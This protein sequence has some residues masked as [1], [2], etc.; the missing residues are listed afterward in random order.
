MAYTNIIFDDINCIP[1]F[2][3]PLQVTFE[4]IERKFK[5]IGFELV[6]M[7]WISSND[8]TVTP[9]VS[10]SVHPECVRHQRPQLVPLVWTWAPHYQVAHGEHDAAVVRQLCTVST[11]CSSCHQGHDHRPYDNTHKCSKCYQVAH[12]E[13]DA[14][15][16]QQLCTVSTKCS[17]CHQGHGHRPYDNTHNKLSVRH[18]TTRDHHRCL[19][20]TVASYLELWFSSPTYSFLGEVGGD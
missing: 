13:H 16:V 14:A 20:V 4:I 8:S 2:R 7:A 6:Q 19:G 11:K 12:G 17:S 3:V 10:A 5:I 15:V 1:G 9:G 18:Y